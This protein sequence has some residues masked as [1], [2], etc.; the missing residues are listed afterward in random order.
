[1]KD[2][3]EGVKFDEVATKIQTRYYEVKGAIDEVIPKLDEDGWSY[4]PE[5]QVLRVYRADQHWD[6]VAKI[7]TF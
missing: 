2:E 1:M 6:K 3:L 4:S 7:G 5:G